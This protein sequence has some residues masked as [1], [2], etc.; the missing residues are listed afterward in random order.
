MAIYTVYLSLHT[1]SNK[2]FLSYRL[3]IAH[4]IKPEAYNFDY[5]DNKMKLQLLGGM[6]SCEAMRRMVKE[7]RRQLGTVAME[8]AVKWLNGDKTGV[9]PSEEDLVKARELVKQEKRTGFRNTI[10]YFRSELHSNQLKA[11]GVLDNRIQQEAVY[12]EKDFISQCASVRQVWDNLG[13]PKSTQGRPQGGVIHPYTSFKTSAQSGMPGGKFPEHVEKVTHCVSNDI[14]YC[15]A[16][17]YILSLSGGNGPR[18]RL[19]Q[20][21]AVPQHA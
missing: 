6:H 5:S 10:V 1:I 9:A 12:A 17:I 8:S 19:Q 20:D 18:P 4:Y 13:R 14:T 21:Q 2:S 11:I 16:S 7:V 3:V 15:S